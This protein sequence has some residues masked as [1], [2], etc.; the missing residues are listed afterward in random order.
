M[1]D[2]VLIELGQVSEETKGPD[3]GALEDDISDVFRP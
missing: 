1:N 2:E 3:K